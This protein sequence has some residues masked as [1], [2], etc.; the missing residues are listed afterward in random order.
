MLDFKF[1]K[2]FKMLIICG[3]EDAKLNCLVYF[4]HSQARIYEGF[5]AK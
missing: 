1:F 5:K 2:Y 4:K 3:V